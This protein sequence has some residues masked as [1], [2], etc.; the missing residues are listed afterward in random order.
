MLRQRILTAALLIPLALGAVFLL[1]NAG[2]A[3]ALAVLTLIGADE[4]G[5]MTGASTPAARG[6]RVAAAA[7]ALAVAAWL[8]TAPLPAA[9]LLS[10]GALA[11][12]GLIA[13]LVR[14]ERGG[15][16]TP[17]A[18]VAAWV[19]GFLLLVPAWSALVWIHGRPDGPWL[20]LVLF[21][22]VWLADAGAYFAGRRFGARKLAPRTSPGKTVEGLGGGVVAAVAGGALLVA[23]APVHLP[24]PALVLPLLVMTVAASVAGDLFESMAKRRAGVKDSGQLLPGHG[25][26]LDRVDSLTAAAP[27]FAGGLLWL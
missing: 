6:L 17:L 24:G 14:Y 4:W 13:L 9:V 8:L 1:P 23:L 11:W 16:A 18:G 22:L 12:I 10:V 20:V 26:V 5:R 2:F 19:L 25:G 27:V 15:D 21:L 7:G 3:L